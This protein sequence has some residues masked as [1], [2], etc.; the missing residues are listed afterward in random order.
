MLQRPETIYVTKPLFR[1]SVGLPHIAPSTYCG[2]L[3]FAADGH[4]QN[5]WSGA[6]ADLVHAALITTPHGWPASVAAR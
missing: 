3:R 2:S 1:R 5:T 6:R 4:A